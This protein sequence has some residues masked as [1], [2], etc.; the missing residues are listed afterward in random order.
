MNSSLPIAGIPWVS[1]EDYAQ[2]KAIMADA[3]LF[4][5]SYRAWLRG[6]ETTERDWRE[7][8]LHPVRI[9][10]VPADFAGWCARRKLR[11]DAV[12]RRQFVRYLLAYN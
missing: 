8:G 3:A 9:V 4:P 2:V 1:E 6:A 5:Q 7:Q 12:A 11:M 10:I